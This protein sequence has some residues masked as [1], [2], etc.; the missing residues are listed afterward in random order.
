MLRNWSSRSPKGVAPS[1]RTCTRSILSSCDRT[2]S[3]YSRSSTSGPEW[4]SGSAE[5]TA[6]NLC[7]CLRSLSGGYTSHSGRV[8]SSAEH[9]ADGI[10]ASQT[11]KRRR[12]ISALS[13]PLRIHQS[14]E[15]LSLGPGSSLQ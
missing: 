6:V 3:M 5:Q 15:S 8:Q 11:A 1:A 10:G 7:P 13:V 9:Y 14:E 4:F 12:G 2:A